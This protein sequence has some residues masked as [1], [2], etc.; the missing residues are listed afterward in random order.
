MV[1]TR[2]PVV[3]GMDISLN[4]WGVICLNE[5]GNVENYAFLTNKKGDCE[6]FKGH[7]YLFKLSKAREGELR[8]NFDSIR[9][10][11]SIETLAKFVYENAKP[12]TEEAFM[13]LEGYAYNSVDKYF[14]IAE[15][16]GVL[17]DT[18]FGGGHNLRIHSPTAV[19]V[20]ATNNGLCFK[21]DMVLEAER[22]GFDVPRKL[23]RVTTKKRKGKELEEYDGVGTDL[24]DAFFL[25]R[26]LWLE[27]KVRSGEIELEELLEPERRIFLRTS[28][29][30]PVNLLDRP[31]I[32]RSSMPNF[33]YWSGLDFEL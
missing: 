18:L 19:K 15:F 20:F 26:M 11:A 5:E 16:I 28:K 7:G 12:G 31:F 25:A 14:Y 22:L 3:F 29:E 33:P 27:L 1:D 9:R 30:Y 6:K 8:E 4:H 32:H 21:K 17:K 23:I 24:A 13:S 10:T 2:Q